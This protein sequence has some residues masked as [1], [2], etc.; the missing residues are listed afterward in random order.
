MLILL[1]YLKENRYHPIYI[2]RFLRETNS[3]CKI[4]AQFLL[5][6][7]PEIYLRFGKKLNVST[8]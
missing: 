6:S 2:D 7:Y 1:P 8:Q 5:I 4:K 3:I